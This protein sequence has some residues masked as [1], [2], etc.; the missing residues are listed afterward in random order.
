M[1]LRMAR[2]GE[3]L[4]AHPAELGRVLHRADADDRALARHQPRHRVVGADRARVGQADRGAG[5]VV[6]GQLALRG[7]AG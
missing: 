3:R 7:P 6:G 2:L 1:I 5:E 4:L